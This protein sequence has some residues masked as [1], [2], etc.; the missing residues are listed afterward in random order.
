MVS[1]R[2]KKNMP[3][4]KLPLAYRWLVKARCNLL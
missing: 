1:G 4:I 3:Q 2:M